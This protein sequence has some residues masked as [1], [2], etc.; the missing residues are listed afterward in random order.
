MLRAGAEV[1]LGDDGF[2]RAFDPFVNMSTTLLLHAL[3][4]PGEVAA[5]DVFSLHTT[6]AARA[7]H[8]EAGEI[9][10]GKLADLVLLRDNSP[11]PLLPENVVYH[12][13]VGALSTDVSHVIVDGQVVVADG[14]IRMVDEEAARARAA[15]TISKLWDGARRQGC[16]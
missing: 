14:E 12:L 11:S 1:S 7:L 10:P 5:Q 8:I 16:N 4:T 2:I 15:Q 13:V 9:A 6:R 3:L